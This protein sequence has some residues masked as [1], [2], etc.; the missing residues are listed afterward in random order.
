MAGNGLEMKTVSALA[1]L[2]KLNIPS[3]IKL[4]FSCNKLG[5][6]IGEK[7]SSISAT[8]LLGMPKNTDI[9]GK[10]LFEA[11]SQNKVFLD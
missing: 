2:L 5:D 11:I 9:A 6:Y 10:S 7:V 1:A 3:L 4:D 8:N